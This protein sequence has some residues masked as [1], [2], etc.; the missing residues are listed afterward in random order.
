MKKKQIAALEARLT[1]LEALV[2]HLGEHLHEFGQ[3]VTDAH[4][5]IDHAF[6]RLNKNTDAIKVLET[7]VDDS[8]APA[9]VTVKTKNSHRPW[10][11]ADTRAVLTQYKNGVPME[12]IAKRMGRSKKAV[13]LR[14]YSRN[15][16]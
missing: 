4:G 12:E 14:I 11:Q 8:P 1:E 3:Q 2:E 16:R 6:S 7:P 5:R 9:R 10:T 15:G 13:A